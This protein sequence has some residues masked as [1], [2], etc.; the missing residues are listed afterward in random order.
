MKEINIKLHE[1]NESSKGKNYKGNAN[2]MM[3]RLVQK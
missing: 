1:N 3:Y 2:N